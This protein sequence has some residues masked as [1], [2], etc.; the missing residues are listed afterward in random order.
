MSHYVRARHYSYLTGG[1][2]TVD[3]L[4]P[5]EST[6]GYVRGRASNF[7]DPTGL[8]T[9]H[10]DGEHGSGCVYI[11]P[12]NCPGEP[13][14]YWSCP[15]K[16]VPAECLNPCAGMLGSDDV[17]GVVC[18]GGVAYLCVKPGLPP[19]D[20]QAKC[21]KAHERCHVRK[22]PHGCDDWGKY[23]MRGLRNGWFDP[24]TE[25]DECGCYREEGEC[26]LKELERLKCLPRVPG[27]KSWGKRCGAIVSGL[28]TTVCDTGG[29]D[30]SRGNPGDLK[31]LKEL[32]KLAEDALKGKP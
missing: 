12:H 10:R 13:Y 9:H 18:C 29:N 21:A 27:D 5:S 28:R 30:C 22:N 17:A 14:G 7:T 1:W 6:Y 20:P 8:Q 19:G 11:S 16:K 23:R 15:P 32:C 24:G 31:K 4:W 2:S 26:L 3:P 25:V